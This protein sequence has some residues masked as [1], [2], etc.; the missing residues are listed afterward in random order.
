MLICSLSAA[1]ESRSGPLMLL[2][3]VIDFYRATDMQISLPKKL[4]FGGVQGSESLLAALKT[5]ACLVWDIRQAS[6]SPQSVRALMFR[7]FPA[8]PFPW[9]FEPN[10]YSGWY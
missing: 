6:I 9:R 1:V 8:A 5:E 3:A 2:L 4:I 10:E 7:A